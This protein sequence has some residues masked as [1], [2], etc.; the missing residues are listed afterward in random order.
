MTATDAKPTIRPDVASVM[1]LAVTPIP[2]LLM[3]DASPA[4]VLSLELSVTAWAVPVPTWMEMDP[5]SVSDG[6]VIS[7]R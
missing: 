1:T 6:L 5:D 7:L 4:R 3:A 2:A